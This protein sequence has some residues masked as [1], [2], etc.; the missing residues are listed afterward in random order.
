MGLGYDELAVV[1]I[2]PPS[3]LCIANMTVCC[4]V[5][6]AL[7]HKQ[8]ASLLSL[9]FYALPSC[10]CLCYFALQRLGWLAVGGTERREVLA[11]P[12]IFL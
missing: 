10:R 7:M 5:A 4:A 12:V 3:V 1:V 8:L 9:V 2:T 6:G 11:C